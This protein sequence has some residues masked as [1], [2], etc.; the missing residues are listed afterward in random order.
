MNKD[1][2]IFFDIDYTLFDTARFQEKLF[3]SIARVL[4]I[5]VSKVA[6]LHEKVVENLAVAKGFFDPA[7][8]AKLMAQE[9]GD[10]KKEMVILDALQQDGNFLDN[11]YE[12]TVEVIKYIAGKVIIGIFSKG[13]T[14]FQKRKLKDIE[15]FFFVVLYAFSN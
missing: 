4:A 8:Y 3:R 14:T 9:I 10:E 2:I 12:E 11:Y 1:T 5:D 13:E 6:W 7:M 15:H